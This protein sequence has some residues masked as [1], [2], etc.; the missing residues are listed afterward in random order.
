[1][2]ARPL[3][4]AI[5]SG[6]W[7][8]FRPSLVDRS[9]GGF[10]VLPLSVVVAT[11]AALVVGSFVW[12]DGSG[13]VASCQPMYRRPPLSMSIELSLSSALLPAASGRTSQVVPLSSL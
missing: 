7:M 9:T 13:Y 12:S 10:H 2:A 5:T 8:L 6:N 4:P 1:M 3:S 11:F